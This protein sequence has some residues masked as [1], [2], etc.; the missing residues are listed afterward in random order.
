MFH[1]K[2][3]VMCLTEKI[4]VLDEPHSY[5]S[6][7]SVGSEFNVNSTIGYIFK[8]RQKKFT[9]ISVHVAAM[10]SPKLASIVHKEATEKMEN[11]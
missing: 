10:R 5:M 9:N 2:K 1:S 7:S 6:Y 8:K 3:A 4:H 11:S